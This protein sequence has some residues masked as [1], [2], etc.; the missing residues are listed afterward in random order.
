MKQGQSGL[1]DEALE[2]FAVQICFVLR[3]SLHLAIKITSGLRKAEQIIWLSS[4]Y[5]EERAKHFPT[6]EK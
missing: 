2:T 6:T 3:P 1:G 5:G 4:L